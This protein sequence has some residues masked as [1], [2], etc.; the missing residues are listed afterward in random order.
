MK[1]LKL[2]LILFFGILIVLGS[3]PAFILGYFFML[4]KNAFVV[5]GEKLDDHFHWAISI[6]ETESKKIAGQKG[7]KHG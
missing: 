4:S 7:D 6:L 1:H 3:A 5:G 2:A